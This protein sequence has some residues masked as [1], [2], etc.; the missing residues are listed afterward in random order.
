MQE[1][2]INADRIEKGLLAEVSVLSSLRELTA[3]DAAKAT[4]AYHEAREELKIK[5]LWLLNLDKQARTAR[6]GGDGRGT[7]RCAALR[8]AGCYH[9]S[10]RVVREWEECAG[11]FAARSRSASRQTPLALPRPHHLPPLPSPHAVPPCPPLSGRRSLAARW[12][13]LFGQT[14]ETYWRLKLS[15]LLY[16]KVKN[17][18][19]KFQN[20]YATLRK[21][22]RPSRRATARRAPVCL[23][24]SMLASTPSPC[25]LP[26][27]RSPCLRSCPD[28]L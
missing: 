14:L 24:L 27:P 1:D 21:P 4:Q 6:R 8:C 13:P 12:P 20:R 9:L 22:A 15:S 17:E 18:R 11:Q 7:A 19:N 16:E 5:N 26:L 2:L 23:R 3:C 28:L 25:L 10:M